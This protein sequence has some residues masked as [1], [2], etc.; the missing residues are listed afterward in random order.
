MMG[1]GPPRD[2]RY[3]LGFVTVQKRD[4]PGDGPAEA[5]IHHTLRGGLRPGEEYS[6]PHSIGARE[7]LKH[8]R[9]ILNRMRGD[10]CETH[11]FHAGA[12]LA[13]GTSAACNIF[14]RGRSMLL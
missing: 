7:R 14:S 10:D 3:E 12:V 6:R 13:T 11:A 1:A 2:V 8:R 4:I 5:R 9:V